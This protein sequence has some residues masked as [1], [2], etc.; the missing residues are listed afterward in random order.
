MKRFEV[1]QYQPPDGNA[2]KMKR[3]GNAV[4][5]IPAI[6]V[7]IGVW[8]TLAASFSSAQVAA[9]SIWPRLGGGMWSWVI[10]R[11][12][13]APEEIETV[14]KKTVDEGTAFLDAQ[15]DATVFFARKIRLTKGKGKER[16]KYPDRPEK[17]D[18]LRIEAEWQN[19]YLN[20]NRGQS[21]CFITLD[22]IRGI[23]LQYLPR[24][25][26][27]FPKAPAGRNWNVNILAGSRFSFL[28]ALE[29]SARAFI[30]AVASVL[31]QRGLELKFS[32][33]GLMWENVTPAQAADMGKPIG[34]SVLVTMVAVAGPADRAGIRP[35]DAI[36]EVN[37]SRV[38][39]FSHFSLLLDGLPPGTKASLL[40]LRRL[41]DPS[42]YPEPSVWK[43]LTVEME[44]R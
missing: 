14:F 41:K 6:A 30:N 13:L 11:T 15:F 27:L 29:D 43:T 18:D 24:A 32:R 31:A 36:L 2:G 25:R 19:G 26:E 38:R 12:D 20:Q 9:P 17:A 44:A 39:N 5:R 23:D 4:R 7:G 35:L 37:G 28:F 3:H 42:L 8:L 40:L 22:A 34:E 16:K 21:Y 1:K 33:F 10:P